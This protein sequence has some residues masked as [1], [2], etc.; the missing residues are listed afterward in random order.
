MDDK[1][2]IDTIKEKVKF[3]V[4]EVKTRLAV[5]LEGIKSKLKIFVT[6]AKAKLW[7]MV[8]EAKIKK[9]QLSADAKTK[10]TE[11]KGQAETLQE[12]PKVKSYIGKLKYKNPLKLGGIFVVVA[13]CVWFA[14][15][16]LGNSKPSDEL[17]FDTITSDGGN[18]LV[19]DTKI[20]SR[21]G[22]EEGDNKYVVEVEYEIT[23]KM[24]QEQAM[25]VMMEL[26]Y[27]EMK[28]QGLPEYQIKM[29]LMFGGLTVG[30]SPLLGEK[31]FKVGDRKKI[32]DEYT[33]VKAESGWRLF[34]D[35]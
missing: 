10:L 25:E 30:L 20:L 26:A 32:T 28:A 8:E 2:A 17:L 31:P 24:N 6:Q 15:I 14:I 27:K 1:S 23:W 33:F 34:N 12:H 13:F 18:G 35:D 7:P 4:T 16:A 11:I 3:V 9:T 21:D 5:M 19:Y 29:A 22:F